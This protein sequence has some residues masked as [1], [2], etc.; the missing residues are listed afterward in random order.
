[1]LFIRRFSKEAGNSRLQSLKEN[2]ARD[3]GG[4]LFDTFA[5]KG[6][7]KIPRLP[8]WLK[9]PIPV[10]PS[11]HKMMKSLEGLNLST[12]SLFNF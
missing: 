11:Y 8:E 2:L 7:S 1:M 4:K 5:T 9:I 6:S 12:V 3:G 10:G